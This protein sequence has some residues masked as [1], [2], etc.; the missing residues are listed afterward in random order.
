MAQ[1]RRRE[2]TVDL[3][4][5]KIQE[6]LQVWDIIL[7]AQRAKPTELLSIKAGLDEAFE[8]DWRDFRPIRLLR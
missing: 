3:S 8:D 1:T 6:M 2:A 5:L 7:I 4:E